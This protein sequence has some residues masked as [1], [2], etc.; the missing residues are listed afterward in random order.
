MQIKMKCAVFLIATGLMPFTSSFSTNSYKSRFVRPARTQLFSEEPSTG[1]TKT[2]K[3]VAAEIDAEEKGMLEPG[4]LPPLKNN[5][6]NEDEKFAGDDDWIPSSEPQRIPG[7]RV[8][9]D[10]ELAAQVADLRKL[11]E[12]W[13]KERVMQEY[14]DARILGWTGM[15][16]MYNSRY[17]MFFLVVGLLT[18]YWTGVTIPGQVEEMLRIGGF[19]G[20]D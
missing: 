11:E 8:L 7:R 5:L 14:E 12:K 4:Q 18:E 19:I 10:I 13:R 6:Y 16:E 1:T 3:E 2:A 15:A 17:A 9:S 20:L